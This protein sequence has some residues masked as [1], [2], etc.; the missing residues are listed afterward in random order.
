M[1]DFRFRDCRDPA[2]PDGHRGMRSAL[3]ALVTAAALVANTPLPAC[4]LWAAAG[5]AAAGG[6]IL[7]KNRDWKPDHTQELRLVRP[8][9]GHAYFGLYAVGNDQP[10]LKGGTNIHGLTVVSATAGSIPKKVRD[11]QPGKRGVLA[12]LLASY[13]SCDEILAHPQGIFASARAG[14]FLISDRSK[15]L[16]VEVGLAGRFAIRSAERGTLA[17]TNHFLEGALADFN[18]SIGRSSASRLGRINELLTTTP[19]PYGTAAFARMSKDQHAGPDNS[20]WRTGKTSRTMSSWIAETPAQGA[21]RVRVLLANPGQPETTRT[22]VLDAAF[23]RQES[24]VVPAG[25]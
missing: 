20:L 22:F 16:A 17:H 14:I 6:T 10:G 25:G 23:W 7:C 8:K 18:K 3:V 11:H 21:P 24:G 9:E 5:E 4:T 19:P 12:T 2:A 13:R 1:T 15:I